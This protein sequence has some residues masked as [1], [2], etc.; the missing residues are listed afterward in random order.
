MTE[1]YIACVVPLYDPILFEEKCRMLPEERRKRIAG[2]RMQKDK[3]RSAGAGLL[4]EYGLRKHGFTLLD[5]IPQMQKV[6]VAEGK[7]GKPYI[8]GETLQF[9][10]SHSGTYAAAVFSSV[11]TG[12]DIEQI[13]KA[14]LRLAQRFFSKDEYRY[15]ENTR[16]EEQDRVF[17]ELWTKKE[18]YIKAVGKGMHLPLYGFSVL[19]GE[20]SFLTWDRPVGYCLSV[21]GQQLAET[22][23]FEIDLRNSI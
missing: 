3:C 19:S 6:T 18:S 22:E 17:S 4:L 15:L 9:N 7:Y 10:L 14:N 5:E 8:K 16:K 21:C 11:E 13:R 1:I 23:I 12:I 20:A 2:C